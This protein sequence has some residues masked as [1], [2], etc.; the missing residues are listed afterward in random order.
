MA[1][2]SSNYNSHRFFPAE[3]KNITYM[4]NSTARKKNKTN[5]DRIL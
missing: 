4:A 2:I 5:L 3:L 1:G